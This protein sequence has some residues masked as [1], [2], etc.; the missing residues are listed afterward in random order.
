MG[1]VAVRRPRLVAAIALALMVLCGGFGAGAAAQMKSGGFV[2]GELDSVRAGRYLDD[3]FPGS[4]PNFVLRL[5]ADDGADSPAA[6]DAADRVVA[7]LTSTPGVFNVQSYWT[8]RADLRAALRGRDGDQGLVIAALSGAEPGLAAALADRLSIDAGPVRVTAGGA[9]ATFADMNS[10]ISHDLVVAE[11]VAIPVTAILLT[12][13]FGSVVAAALPI[14]IGVFAV[15]AT[16]GIL[17]VLTAF[18]EVSI[19]A[20][21]MTTAL[22]LALAIDYSLFI[23]SRYREELAAGASPPVAVRRSLRTAGHT[24]LYSALV[25]ALSLAALLIFPQYFFRSFAYAGIAVV[26]AATA[27]ALV[28]LPALLMLVGDRIHAGD[29]RGRLRR[30]RPDAARPRRDPAE[31][32]WFRLATRVM[33][34]PLPVALATTALLLLLCSPFLGVRL[35]YP[36]DRTLPPQAPSR[37][38]GDVLR[39]QFD[40]DFAASATVVLPDFRGARADVGEY[41]RRLSSV[42]GVVA[43]LSGD[44]VCRNGL[45]VA[46]GLPHMTNEGGAY[47]TVATKVDPYS[48][49]GRSQLE[50]LRAVPAPAP[51]L[52]TGAAALNHD[53]VAEITGRLPLAGALI[54]LTTLVLLFLFTGSVVVAVKA[55]VLN[56]LSLAATFGAMVWV[57]QEGNLSGLLGFTPTGTLNLALPILMFSLAFGASMDYEIF[58][59][60]RIREEWLAGPPTAAG[61]ARA[62]AL[63]IART[64]RIFTAAALLMSIVFLAVAT[65]EVSMM[66]LFGLGCALAVVSDATVIRGLLVPALMRLAGT[67]N[68]WAPGPLARLHRRFGVHEPRPSAPVAPRPQ[69]PVPRAGADVSRC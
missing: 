23:V 31:A 52:V 45:R 4:Q 26:V 6:R 18:A 53:S 10:Q 38:V 25:V 2:T 32:F 5:T 60:S 28:V 8:S 34:R 61:N 27:A 3:H 49:A 68:W 21:N 50:A 14:V 55:L 22:G 12:V 63:G 62:V 37:V 58:L 17:R 30:S 24:V 36:D 44:A 57:F 51:A 64:G 39:T 65:S 35:G 9:G 13:V 67:W 66:K 7:I 42:P 48:A 56:V 59:L 46:A 33:R 15:A 69:G 43:V 20:L 16:L 11:A 40:A 19:F 54:A 47:L 1:D 29:V 41:A